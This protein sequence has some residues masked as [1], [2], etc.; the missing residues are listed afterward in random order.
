MS[1]QM[2]DAIWR[3][4][5]GVLR[6][7]LESGKDPNSVDDKLG[8]SGLML[9]VENHQ[10][11]VLAVLLAAG[12]NPNFALEN[13]WTAL[14]QAVDSECDAQQQTGQ[15]ADGALVGMLLEAGANPDASLEPP[16]RHR[17]P[18]DMAASYQCEAVINALAAR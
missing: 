17:T 15:P 4:D 7:L 12:A 14:H 9:A 8:W 13:G 18:R 11:E 16:A 1:R 10:R 6:D 2:K 3:G 5:V